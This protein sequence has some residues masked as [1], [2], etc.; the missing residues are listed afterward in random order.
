MSIKPGKAGLRQPVHLFLYSSLSLLC[1]SRL[2]IQALPFMTEYTHVHLIIAHPITVYGLTQTAFLFKPGFF[3]RLKRTFVIRDRIQSNTM[4]I[5]L[6]KG[7]LEHKIQGFTAIAMGSVLRTT[8][9]DSQYTAL[10]VPLDI[11]DTNKA[12]KLACIQKPYAELKVCGRSL[13]LQ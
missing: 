8:Y 11:V 1:A 9:P 13:L 6:F 5:K 12:Y 2:Q 3:I 4:Q 7:K 10:I